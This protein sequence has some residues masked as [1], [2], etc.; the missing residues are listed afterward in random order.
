M[1]LK[2]IIKEMTPPVLW[3]LARRVKSYGKRTYSGPYSNWQEAQSAGPGY[4]NAAIFERVRDAALRVK[5]GQAVYER[6]SVCFAEESFHW[7]VLAGLLAAA[8]QTGGELRVL[9]FGGAFGSVYNQH[10][11]FLDRL[12]SVSWHVIEQPHVVAFG[13][14]HFED[15]RLR[16]FSSID[17]SVQIQ[18]PNVA[19]FSSVLQYL[20]RPFDALERVLKVAPSVLIVDR[21]SVC[22]GLVD[23]LFV[24]HV[25][26]KLFKAALPVHV[27]SSSQFDEKLLRFGYSRKIPMTC[28]EEPVRGISF[29]SAIYLRG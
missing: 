2:K 8:A 14:S 11:L 24:Q 22:S 1:S 15:G 27:F 17:E 7:P 25:P 20:E 6:D 23:R 21:T 29:A 12:G 5:Q 16:F 26:E 4:D 13:R 10:R 3:K 18:V 9:D 19:L 28:E